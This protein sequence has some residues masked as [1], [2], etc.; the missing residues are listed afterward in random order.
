LIDLIDRPAERLAV[1]LVY[2]HPA[3]GPTPMVLDLCSEHLTM[4]HD[5]ANE[6]AV[7]P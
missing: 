5:P 6:I 1:G 2:P 7:L 3:Y 4:A